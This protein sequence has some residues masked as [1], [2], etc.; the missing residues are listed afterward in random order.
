MSV[1]FRSLISEDKDPETGKLL[2][3]LGRI[4]FW[5]VFGFCIYFWF[6]LP[7]PAFPPNLFQT[8]VFLM[9]YNVSKKGVKSLDLA[10]K[11]WVG[12]KLGPTAA[13]FGAVVNETEKA[14]QAEDPAVEKTDALP[15]GGGKQE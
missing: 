8:L 13:G 2:I 7:I 3:S 14:Q 11:S 5:T 12:T 4:C 15:A 9:M 10:M 1:D 6:F